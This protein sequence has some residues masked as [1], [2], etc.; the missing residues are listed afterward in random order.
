MLEKQMLPSPLAD[1]KCLRI[2]RKNR[3]LLDNHVIPMLVLDG[4]LSRISGISPGYL[5]SIQIY[6]RSHA[7]L[8]PTELA[9]GLR[10]IA[11]E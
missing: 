6:S 1:G 4:L 10:A 3:S 2:Y 9:E 7:H 11:C 8:C 5:F